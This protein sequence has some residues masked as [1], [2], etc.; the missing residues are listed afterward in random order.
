MYGV[1]PEGSYSRA[2]LKDQGILV[3]G[4]KPEGGKQAASKIRL[5]VTAAFLRKIGF[6]QLDRNARTLTGLVG[7]LSPGASTSKLAEQIKNLM[8]TLQE[9]SRMASSTEI[10][11][12]HHLKK[13]CHGGTSMECWQVAQVNTPMTGGI[14]SRTYATLMGALEK[15]QIAQYQTE[16][17][18]VSLYSPIQYL[19][20]Q[21]GGS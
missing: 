15:T 9:D 5:Y 14:S 21:F 12:G 11:G 3:A 10:T 13:D 16:P 1:P 18:R 20:P 7:N 2:F 4:Q 6:R 17:S 8:K 19:M